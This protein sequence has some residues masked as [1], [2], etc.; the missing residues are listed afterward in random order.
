L[1][2]FLGVAFV[3]Q[4]KQAG[5]DFKGEKEPQLILTSCQGN[6]QGK[7][8][9]FGNRL[10]PPGTVPA[11]IWGWKRTCGAGQEKSNGSAAFD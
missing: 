6:W 11:G 5:E 2:H 1:F 4:H 10:K 3:I 7:L 9:T 8:G